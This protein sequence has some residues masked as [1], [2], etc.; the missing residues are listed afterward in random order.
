MRT[1]RVIEIFAADS[2]PVSCELFPP[3]IG[4][5]LHDIRR[6][7][8]VDRAITALVISVTC[9]AGGSTG[10]HTVEGAREVSRKRRVGA[11]AHDLL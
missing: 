5:P 6:V 10:D 3:K 2:V 1:V 9:G 8:R 7:V 4:Q 11:R